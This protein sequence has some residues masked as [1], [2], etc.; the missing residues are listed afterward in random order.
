MHDDFLD[1]LDAVTNDAYDKALSS[2][3]VFAF[4]SLKS[5]Y[6]RDS[7]GYSATVTRD[8]KK[9]GTVVD[10]G[11]GGAPFLQITPADFKAFMVEAR[12]FFSATEPLSDSFIEETYCAILSMAATINRKR[13]IIASS[14]RDGDRLGDGV[15]MTITGGSKDL[16]NVAA[17]LLSDKSGVASDEPRLWVKA[18]T[19]FVAAADLV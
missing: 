10:E 19:K 12:S 16:V 3:R 17:Y 4:T 11:N 13:A 8:G 15:Y 18:Q 1:A 14:N 2:D 6:G 7:E 5:F 9:I